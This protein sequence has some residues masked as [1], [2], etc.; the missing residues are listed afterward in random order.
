MRARYRGLTSGMRDSSSDNT[1]SFAGHAAAPAAGT[2][3][4]SSQSIDTGGSDN[5]EL[6]TQ[7]PRRALVASRGRLPSILAIED[8]DSASGKRR[9]SDRQ[10][11]PPTTKAKPVSSPIQEATPSGIGSYQKVSNPSS[12]SDLFTAYQDELTEYKASLD[13]A[14]EEE[15][16]LQAR[17]HEMAAYANQQFNSLENATHQEMTSMAQQLQVLNSEL[18]AAKQE[19]EGAT[20]RIEELE[21]YRAMSNGPKLLSYQ[22][23]CI[24]RT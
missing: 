10:S 19:D 9:T 6:R 24:G 5:S 7:L 2:Q 17:L 20:Y 15:S 21:E 1:F 18:I 14:T 8:A 22:K 23:K 11:S 4:N 13:N 3:S 12:G 16:V